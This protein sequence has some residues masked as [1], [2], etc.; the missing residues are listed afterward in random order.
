MKTVMILIKPRFNSWSGRLSFNPS[1]NWALQISHAYIKSPE[2]LHTD[3]NVHRTTASAEYALPLMN[4]NHLTLR[5]F[6]E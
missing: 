2:A 3:E 6:G 1:K 4:N 5:L